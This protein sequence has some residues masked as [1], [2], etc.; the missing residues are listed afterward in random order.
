M[1]VP[2]FHVSGKNRRRRTIGTSPTCA[3]EALGS[4]RRTSA[5]QLDAY[6]QEKDELHLRLVACGVVNTGIHVKN[7]C[8]ERVATTVKVGA[9]VMQPAG[10]V[11]PGG[12]R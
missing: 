10:P 7:R 12:P 6:R 1:A 4:N 11:Q 8:F 5:A 9:V 3:A 2:V